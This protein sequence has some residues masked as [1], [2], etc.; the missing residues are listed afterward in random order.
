MKNNKT[1]WISAIIPVFAMMTLGACTKNFEEY[2]TDTN[3]VT[4]E[5]LIPD[6]N[7][8]GGFFPGLQ[9]A[10]TSSNVIHMDIIEHVSAGTYAGYTTVTLP[11][12]FNNVY[13]I[14]IGWDSYNFMNIGLGQ[15][16]ATV[17]E[18]QRRGADVSAPDF[19]A[20]A[21]ILQVMSMEKVTKVYGPV[22]YSAY[23]A[24]GTSVAYDKEEDLYNA[25]FVE[26]EEA[27][28]ALEAYV[29]QFPGARPFEKF[30]RFY[31]GD[32]TKWIKYANSLRL[33]LAMRLA[34]I[35]PAKAK[36]EAEKAVADGV[37]SLNEDNAA[38]FYENNYQNALYVTAQIW[39]DIR[40]CGTLISYLNG[41]N[42]PRIAAYFEPSEI[43]PGEY[44]GIRGGGV[45]LDHAILTQYSDVS[46]TNFD[47]ASPTMFLAAAEMYFLRAEGALRGWNMGGSAKELYEKGIIAS[48]TQ[49]G[50]SEALAVNYLN[51]DT[52][53][54]AD[55]VDPVT[56]GNSTP[57]MSDM[58]I[59]WDESDSNERKLERIITQYWIAQF[60][61]ATEAWTTFRR[62]GYPRLFPVVVNESGGLID[63]DIQIRRLPYPQSE[64]QT[65]NAEVTKAVLLLGGP[66][67][68]GT[69]LWWDL[70]QGNF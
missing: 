27:K 57:A 68:G 58:T 31:K 37:I 11:G 21:R 46:L 35:N 38:A 15:T 55:Y 56:P 54:P 53:V 69:R 19:F 7:Y 45:N 20:I 18:L 5:Q 29:Q 13:S 66:D 32:Y 25:F 48:F 64:Y 24:G 67:T 26:L 47:R 59:K 61:D 50:Y 51:D 36:E 23:G 10:Y 6:F 40:S 3:G 9:L 43:S 28:L 16:M 44:V 17:K 22:P 41:Y 4:D 30:D 63:T 14:Y 33:R 1:F 52:S 70:D 34:K 60:P 12:I 39:E 65:N 2:N 49:W 62:T 42:D 8:I